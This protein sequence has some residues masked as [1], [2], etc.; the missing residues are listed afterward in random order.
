MKKRSFTFVLLLLIMAGVSFRNSNRISAKEKKIGSFRYTYKV[1]ANNKVWL[2]KVEICKSKNISTLVIP[3]KLEGKPVYKLGSKHDKV[4]GYQPEADNLFGM[5]VNE[6]NSKLEPRK[7][8]RQVAKIKKIVLPNSVEE[9]TYSCFYGLQNG[10]SI[11]IPKG[12]QENVEWIC[13]EVKWNKFKVSGKNRSY[14]VKNGVLLSKDGKVMYTTVGPLKKMIIP[15]SVKSIESIGCCYSNNTVEVH[16]PKTVTQDYLGSV[17]QSN[18]YVKFRISSK[19][20]KYGIANG[21]I[22]NKKNKQLVVGVTNSDTFIVPQPIECLKYI[23]FAAK[24]V[25]KIVIPAFVKE[26]ANANGTGEYQVDSYQ[27]LSK[28]PPVLNRFEMAKFTFYVPKRSK[29]SY[30]KALPQTGADIR[31]VEK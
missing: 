1:D 10:K 11:N 24:N 29:S 19:N 6:E 30:R 9:I 14:K 23:A 31:I 21:S 12:V 5:Y 8:I 16:I 4:T 3:S 26:V 15:A 2:Q 27:F 13:R 28:K 17:M 18:H 7:I 20:K 22:Y 25:K